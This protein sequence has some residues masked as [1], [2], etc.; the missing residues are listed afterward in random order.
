MLETLVSNPHSIWE[1]RKEERIPSATLQIYNF[2]ATYL[3]RKPDTHVNRASSASMCFKRRWFQRNGYEATPLTPRKM[4]NFLLGDLSEK[5]IQYFIEQGCV[6]PGKLYSQVN[7]GKAIGNFTIQGKPITVY[8]QENLTARI[9]E[10]EVTAHVDGWGCRNS[11]G[12]WELIEIKSAA[13]YGYDSFIENGPGDYLKQASVNMRTER[14][15][16]LG[17]N[18]VR[19][20]Y[21][22]KDT[23]N[24]YDRVFNFSEELFQEVTE[25]YKIANGDEEPVRPYKAKVETFRSKPT[26]R[27][28]L[29]WQCGYCSYTQT[30][31]K[32]EAVKEFKN[33]KPL[34]IYKENQ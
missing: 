3:A 25:E 34:W 20:F 6:G 22:R 4:V 18:S 12:Q 32:E 24:I 31:W 5:T 33:G 15:K 17:V 21:L 14:A 19:F 10:L 9:G 11:D 7:F 26:G 23:G 16:E 13:S 28:V 8:E 30:C 27:K 29:P 1:D 2:I